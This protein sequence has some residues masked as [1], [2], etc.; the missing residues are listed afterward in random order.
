MNRHIR[1]NPWRLARTAVDAADGD[2][3][4][5]AWALLFTVCI[6]VGPSAFRRAATAAPSHSAVLSALDG[7]DFE[8][9]SRLNFGSQRSNGAAA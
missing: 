2:R 6:I 3:A 1:L 9:A 8:D 7:E 5:A 4:V